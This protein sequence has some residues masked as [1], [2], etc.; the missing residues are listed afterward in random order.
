MIPNFNLPKLRILYLA[1]N[2]L[3]GCIPAGLK[4]NCPLIGA[5]NGDINFNP[6]LATQNWANYWNLNEGRCVTATADLKGIQVTIA[7]NPVTDWF[8]I[9]YDAMPNKILIYDSVGKL[10]ETV[11][12]MPEQIEID[13]SH[14]PSGVYLMHVQNKIYKIVKQ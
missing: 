10:L 8:T 1:Q 14:Y 6:N 11:V 7:P 9:R 2:R 4:T 3:E 12:P 5:M 13:W